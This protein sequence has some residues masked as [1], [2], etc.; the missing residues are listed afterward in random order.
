MNPRTH[1]RLVVLYVLVAALLLVLVGRMWTLQVL[2]GEHYQ[3]IA[4]QNRTRDIVVPAVRGM[5]LDDRGE[6]LVR[7]RSALVVSVNR[8]T[9][10]RQDDG[11][12][13]VLKRL[14]GVL[15]TTYDD[16]SKRIR[17][18]SPTVKRPC[19]PGSPYQPI[20]VED[21]VDPKRALQIMERQ[22]DFPGVTAQI[23][24]VREYPEPDGASAAQ[25]LGYL[26][27]V[28]QE[29]LDK[30]K[31]LKVTG[32]SG[33]DLVG[34][35]GLEAQYDRA[36]RGEPGYRR[37]LVDSQGR[38]TGT[39][40]EQPATSGSNLVTSI[41]AGVQGAAEKA[42][43]HAIDSA[44]K[45]GKPADA[46]AAVVMDVRT[47]RMVAMASYP[48]YDPTIWT[49][50]ISQDKYD[51][52]LGKKNG[53]PLISR[54]TQGQF[55]PGSTF[56]ISSVAAAVKDGNSLKG[57]YPCPG[58]YNVG[59]R[60]FTN[61][62]GTAYGPMTLHTALVKSCDTVFYRF[63]YLE[64]KHD[65]G[66]HPKKNPSD[67]MIKMA[68]QYG[69]GTKTGIDLPSESSGRIPD[70]DWKKNYWEATKVANC[71]GAKEGYPDVAKTD[72]ARAA[73]LKA[74]ATE[75]CTEGYVWR[76]GDAA[77]F[78]VG[79]GNVLVTPLQLVRAYAAVANGGKLMTPRLGVAVVRPDGTVVRRIDAPP[80]E[81]LPVDPKVL[82][83]IRDALGEVPKKG[84]AAGAFSGFDFKRVDVGGKTG[85]AEVYGKQDTSW[86]ASF[87]PV[88][89]PRFAVVAM[90]S[91]GGFGAST[92]APAVREIW[93]A[94]YGTKDRKPILKDGKLPSELPKM[95]GQGTAP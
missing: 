54:V 23:Q 27:P 43:K 91:Q 19:W 2:E 66:M 93:E 35:A 88:K 6:P 64:W 20:P 84:T 29:E 41:D 3:E 80:P 14:A 52:L 34:R 79:Q 53:E 90:V 81:K 92:A 83:Y 32:Y 55:A 77:N 9:L 36:L 26:Q 17:L 62:G 68:R 72:P 1:F 22:E 94:M 33:V 18:C 95:P 50:G 31:G 48:S 56:K 78:S 86:F 13:A 39:A 69:F 71:K 44:R 65:G 59:N 38:V 7:N 74:V 5:I 4:A 10:S 63:A 85:T 12:E 11:G 73:Y 8:T 46:G 40:E 45:G 37:V 28:T 61:A 49:G 87:G 82:K 30:R 60:A 58:S 47:G 57:I 42:L 25:V 75:N 76:P 67:P 70:R 24:A 51:A 21:H 16:I 15:G 89:D